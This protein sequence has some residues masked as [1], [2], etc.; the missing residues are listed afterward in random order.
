[1]KIRDRVRE[2][3]RVRAGDLKPNPR[4]W[5]TH[6]KA[7]QD[8]LRGLLA[9]VGYADALLARELPDGSL[10][11]VDCHLRAETTPDAEVPV[12]ILDVTEEE[13]AKILATVDPLAAMAETDAA[14]L[15]A[16][17]AGIE[18]DSDAVRA[19][20]AGVAEAAGLTAAAS[21]NPAP[22]PGARLDEAEALREKW[23]TERGQLWE[24]GQHRL[25]CGDATAKDDVGRLLDGNTPFVMVTDPPYGVDYDPEW[26]HDAGINNSSRMGKVANDDRADWTPAWALFPGDVAYVWHAGLMGAVVEASLRDAG[27]EVRAQIVWAKPR[28]TISRGAYHWQHEPCFYAVRKGATA[29]W[30]GDRKQTTLWQVSNSRE[31]GDSETTHGTQK[32]VE[33]MARPLRNHWGGGAYEPFSG[34]G[35][36]LVAAEQLGVPCL[37]MEIEP[38]YVA[39]ALERLAGM[40]LSPRVL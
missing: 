31:G 6:P 18:T 26:R 1:M 37:A 7:Q 23:K 40:G 24:I 10:E 20:L 13:A 14:A 8:A 33:C 25:L 12:L 27:F 15:E 21:G 36:T 16:L 38:K 34:S 39:V 9:E 2:L 19:L 3:R 22:D 17:L 11:L 28:L 4:N 29:K 35:T 30:T 5:R 32:P